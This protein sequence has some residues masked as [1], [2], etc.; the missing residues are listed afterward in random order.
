MS[1]YTDKNERLNRRAAFVLAI[2]LHAALA[3]ALYVQTSEKPTVKNTA[4]AVA[5]N[6]T[7]KKAAPTP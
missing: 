1:H 4:A 3:V 2:S 7:V 5:T 6:P